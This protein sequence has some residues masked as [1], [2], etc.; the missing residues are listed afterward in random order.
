[1]KRFLKRTLILTAIGSTMSV[2]SIFSPA[3]ALD[4]V[5]CQ[6]GM[7]T[8]LYY[9]S[10]VDGPITGEDVTYCDGHEIFLGRPDV[11]SWTQYCGP[12]D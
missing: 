12:C 10:G 8:I 7:D 1:M 11:Y 6:P 3:H 4:P 9:A 5:Q 2:S